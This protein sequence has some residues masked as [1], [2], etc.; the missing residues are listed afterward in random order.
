M[1]DADKYDVVMLKTMGTIDR[2][3]IEYIDQRNIE[4]GRPNQ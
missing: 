4:I 2:E 1:V 3:V